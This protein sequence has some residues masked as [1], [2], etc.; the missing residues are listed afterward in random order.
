MNGRAII[1][2]S[3]HA[4]NDLS[5]NK[6]R[7]RVANLDAAEGLE[8]IVPGRKSQPGNPN[9]FGEAKGCMALDRSSGHLG[10]FGVSGAGATAG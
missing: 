6:A 2:K 5:L 1:L 7:G 4:P 8:W 9:L 3:G 10:G